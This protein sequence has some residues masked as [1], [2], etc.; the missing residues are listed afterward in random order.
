MLNEYLNDISRHLLSA[1]SIEPVTPMD[2]RPGRW[3]ER[4]CQAELRMPQPSADCSGDA[5]ATENL[6]RHLLAQLTALVSAPNAAQNAPQAARAIH[7]LLNLASWRD[8]SGDDPFRS[9]PC[10]MDSAF[11]ATACALA[12]ALNV[13]RLPLTQVSPAI[14]AR[15][16][17][18][19]NRR[20]LFP[21]SGNQPLTDLPLSS[22]CLLL[23]AAI[24]GGTAE[25]HRWP[26]IR[27][28]CRQIDHCL[29]RL[30]ADGSM[31]G[32]IEVATDTA[33]L[34]MDT[35]EVLHIATR[36]QIDLTAH[37][38]IASLA[39]YPLFAHLQSG[40]FV[41]PG[42]HSMNVSPDAESLFR[43]GQRTSD[44]ALCDLSVWLLRTDRARQSEHAI[45]RLLNRRTL[46]ALED[47]PGRIRL[48]RDGFLPDAGIMFMRGFNLHISMT[49]A[50]GSGH[51]DAGNIC[52]FHREQPVLVD[53]GPGAAETHL[54]SLPTVAGVDQFTEL[55]AG[56]CECASGDENTT[57]YT[58]NLTAAYPPRCHIADYQRTLLL[59]SRT[60]PGIRLIDMLELSAAETVDFHFICAIEPVPAPDGMCIGPVLLQWNG[61]LSPSVEKLS[62]PGL[63]RLTLRAPAADRHRYIFDLTAAR[64]AWLSPSY[65]AGK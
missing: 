26:A 6:R 22:A 18:E 30:P 47:T 63:Y 1:R 24:L 4:A 34:L 43:F 28:L 45:S 41:N 17:A 29:S 48:F 8:L 33:V 65:R 38:R 44:G 12:A 50:T 20:L 39:D 27:K 25:A 62:R 10:G 7:T 31:P 36:R 15:I 3:C 23:M 52:L 11:A 13:L 46:R 58:V 21:L 37:E 64:G 57:C 53:I 16:E 54:H 61:D 14:P 32:G 2:V 42:E 35:L 40:W 59:G 49:G 60:A 5:D 9:D 19:I 55:P 56:I 51:G